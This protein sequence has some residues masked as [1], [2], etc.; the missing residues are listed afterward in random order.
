VRV[1]TPPGEV[2]QV[3]F[4]YVGLLWDPQTNRLRKAWA[5]VMV[6]GYSRHMYAE[7]VFD[8]TI[9]TWLLC[10]QHSF[11]FFGGVPQRVVLDNL[12]AAIIKA[13]SLDQDVEVQRSYRE[14]A[15]HYHF[16][17]DPCLPRKPQHKGKVERGGV[18][19]LQ[20]SMWPLVAPNTALPEANRQLR[21]WLLTTAGL[22]VHGTTR[23]V[24]LTRFEQTERAALQ[25]LPGA[26]YDPAVWKACTLYRDSY[27]TFEKAY[28]SAPWRFIG[29]TLWVR[30]GLKEVRL[31]TAQFELIATHPRAIH[32]GERH[33]HL[34][35]F[36]PEKAEAMTLNRTT[37]QAQ[38]DAIGPATSQVVTEL[39]ASRPIDR[40]RIAVR[41][42]HL[43]QTYTAV[44]LEAACQ[45]GLTHGDA[46]FC[47]LKRLL[48]DGLES[49][50]LLQPPA[51]ATETLVYA[52]SPEE[53]A[54]A[55]LG[56]AAWN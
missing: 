27:V 52:R 42:L 25:P 54:Q 1:E 3:D 30:A 2:A 56:G 22:R 33:T 16:L 19:Y 46:S 26:A 41:V 5:F 13:Y 31:L 47:T 51:A 34:D 7:F 15:E 40:F 48:R 24:P 45:S 17:I 55:I 21:Q 49:S 20:Q 12:K 50:P 29:Q 37:C 39:L 35:H 28:Y 43:A 18:G 6:L 38:A 14:C 44:R 10:H 9:A 23:E 32:P 11:E 53:L 4:G 8:Q 36:P